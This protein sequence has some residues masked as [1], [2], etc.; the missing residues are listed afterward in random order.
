M[1]SFIEHVFLERHIEEWCPQSGPLRDFM[2][3]VCTTLSKNAFMTAEKKL[4]YINWFR[5]YFD[6]PHQ[7]EI[8]E[9]SGALDG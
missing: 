8:L 3:A 1:E 6:Q 5:D 2:E 4:Y 7:K 9:I